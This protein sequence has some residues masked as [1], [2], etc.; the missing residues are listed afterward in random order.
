MLTYVRRRIVR[1]S[2]KVTRDLS[3]VPILCVGALA[4]TTGAL[5]VIGLRVL[6]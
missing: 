6:T 2:W 3:W 1:G 4:A 5:F